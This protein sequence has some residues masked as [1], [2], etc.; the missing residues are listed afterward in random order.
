MATSNKRHLKPPHEPPKRQAA[1]AMEG[2]GGFRHYTPPE[3]IAKR[4][5]KGKAAVVA[6]QRPARR[7]V[8]AEGWPPPGQDNTAMVRVER[9]TSGKPP[10][11]ATVEPSVIQRLEHLES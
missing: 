6:P 2:Q 11:P 1:P 7:V 10:A 3:E 8:E 5:G 9:P 4:E